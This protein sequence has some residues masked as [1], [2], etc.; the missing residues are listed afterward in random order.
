MIAVLAASAD[1]DLKKLRAIRAGD[2]VVDD[3]CRGDWY[4][5]AQDAAAE[6]EQNQAADIFPALAEAGLRQIQRA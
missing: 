1:A 4:H 6:G 3:F 5:R 2:R